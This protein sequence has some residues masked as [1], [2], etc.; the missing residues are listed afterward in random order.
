M[1]HDMLL[2]KL[3]SGEI[4]IDPTKDHVGLDSKP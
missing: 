3:V 2:P 1:T 4:R